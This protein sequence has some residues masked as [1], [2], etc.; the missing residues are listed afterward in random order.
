MQIYVDVC[1]LFSGI[2]NNFRTACDFEIKFY[3]MAPIFLRNN[4]L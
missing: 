2:F 1:I 4:M 3:H